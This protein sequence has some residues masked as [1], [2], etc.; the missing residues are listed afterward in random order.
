MPA[1]MQ[2]RAASS[3]TREHEKQVEN[4]L[5]CDMRRKVRDTLI[6]MESVVSEIEMVDEGEVARLA[7]EI[8][9]AGPPQATASQTVK[10]PA[11][12]IIGNAP[13]HR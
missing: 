2:A 5:P 3:T 12:K 4:K 11:W 7:I 13:L 1:D 9:C 6:R 8:L 10:S